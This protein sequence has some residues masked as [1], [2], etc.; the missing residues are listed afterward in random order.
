MV[1]AEGALA[2]LAEEREEVE[3]VAVGELAVLAD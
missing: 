3:L 1:E 2:G